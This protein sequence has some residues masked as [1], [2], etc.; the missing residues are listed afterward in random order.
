MATGA[1]LPSRF[2][3]DDQGQLIGVM[4]QLEVERLG[5]VWLQLDTAIPEA[6]LLHGRSV[7]EVHAGD[8]L[9]VTVAGRVLAPSVV[10]LVPELGGAV[11]RRTDRVG[12]VGS[13]AFDHAWLV[14]DLAERR[15]DVLGEPDPVREAATCWV[16]TAP[17]DTRTRVVAEGVGHLLFDTGSAPQGIWT[18]PKGFEILTGVPPRD[19]P[20]AHEGSAFG[21][22][23]RFVGASSTREVRVG[24]ISLGHPLVTT[25]S[26]RPAPPWAGILGLQPFAGRVVVVDRVSG[27]FGVV[28]PC[29]A[30]GSSPGRPPR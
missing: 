14:L 26:D 22:P 20:V 12:S 4:V 11:D 2:V 24:G 9:A 17:V 3:M 27:R 19:A 18:N 7:P 1:E 25:T 16:G 13:A 10:R 8:S 6:L 30:T 15:V 23:V 5:A 28:G 21:Q 29:A